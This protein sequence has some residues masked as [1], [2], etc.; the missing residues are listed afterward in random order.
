MKKIS[1]ILALLI[2]SGLSVCK[3]Q[4]QVETYSY[5]PGSVTLNDGTILKGMVRIYDTQPWFNQRHIFFIDS[6]TYAANPHANGKKYRFDDMLHYQVG[7]RIFDKA[8]YINTENLQLK[9]LGANDHMLERLT[10]GRITSHRFYD[11]PP[12]VSVDAG[13]EE[14]IK[15]DEAQQKDDLLRG[16]KILCVKDDEKK[17]QNAFDIDMLQ[18]LADVPAVQQKYQSGGYG[19]QPVVKHKGLAAKMVALAKKTAF[20]QDEA[21]AIVAAFN[22]FNAQSVSK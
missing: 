14:K 20:K 9:S 10:M 12:D 19:N 15:R 16:Y 3:A 6:A 22:D 2:I 8:H 7:T 11:Y 18:Y 13:T 4:E 5:H 1:M 21:D 17:Q